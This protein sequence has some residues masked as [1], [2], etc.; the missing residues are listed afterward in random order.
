MKKIVVVLLVLCCLAAPAALAEPSRFEAGELRVGELALGATREAAV[1]AFGEPMYT[2]TF[3]QGDAV[4]YTDVYL[5]NAL[6][7]RFLEDSLCY[8]EWTDSGLA[9]PRAISIGMTLDRVTASFYVDLAQKESFIL[10]E[11]GRLPENGAYLPPLGV[12]GRE[13]GVWTVCYQ[14]P[15]EPYPQTDAADPASYQDAMHA[16]LLIEGDETTNCVKRILWMVGTL[17]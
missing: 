7:L 15:V 8:A 16:T 14:A 4:G 5:Y 9:G 10:Y 3:S 6:E 12:I 13:N 17:R 11:N 2:E 1:A